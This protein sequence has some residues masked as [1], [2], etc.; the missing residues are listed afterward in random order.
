MSGR[1][2]KEPSARASFFH[3][4]APVVTS[5]IRGQT[6]GEIVK[7]AA[8]SEADGAQGIAV[9]LERYRPEF[10]T[11]KCL[12][13]IM[14]P[15]DLPFMFF[16]YRDDK[17]AK[18]QSDAARQEV[19]LAAA[20]AGAEVIDV[21]ADLYDPH[22]MQLTRAPRAVE[23][24]QRLFDEIRKRG[25]VPELSCHTP[26]AV[27][28]E[29]TL[30]MMKTMEARGAGLVKIVT[31]VD[32]PE[33]LAEA[34]LTTSVLKREMKVPFIHLVSG[35]FARPHR[36]AAAT[37]GGSIVFAVHHYERNKEIT[38]PTVRELLETMR[39]INFSADEPGIRINRAPSP[40]PVFVPPNL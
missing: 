27:N 36:M 14:E 24:Q 6:P 21:M 10:R 38:Q 28:C 34:F 26:C 39:L 5:I 37:L 17:F 29:Q 7:W 15:F 35:A 33:E 8:A 23:K 13:S 16:A 1:D 32:T 12:R 31:R 40:Y 22:P 3:R 11:L 19:L 30:E 2:G 9:D 20:E 18:V 25:A 4:T